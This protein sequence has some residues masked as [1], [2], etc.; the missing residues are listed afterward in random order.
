MDDTE[1]EKI[2]HPICPINMFFEGD[3][4]TCDTEDCDWDTDRR[5]CSMQCVHKYLIKTD[6][7][8]VG[9]AL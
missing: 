1:L 3:E 8:D 7:Y 6:G 9:E 2:V 5:S 4:D